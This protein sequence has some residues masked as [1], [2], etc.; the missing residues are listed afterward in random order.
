MTPSGIRIFS[1]RLL[2]IS[3]ATVA[4]ALIV[5]KLFVA[6]GADG[7]VISSINLNTSPWSAALDE[8]T[9]RLY[10]VNRSFGVLGGSILVQPSGSAGSYGYYASAPLNSA[11]SG[12]VQ[13]QN[14][15]SVVNARGSYVE[16]TVPVGDDPRDAAIDPAHGKVYVTSDD[17]ASVSV[18]D[19]RH[20][21]QSRTV[22]V[23]LR[24]HAV[25]VSGSTG[26]AF[27]V[28]T[29]D[30]TV[31][32]LDV[33]GSRVVRVVHVP[34][35]V[36][37]AGAAVDEATARVFVAGGGSV[38]LLDA[39]SGTMLKTVYLQSP[40][41]QQRY[42]QAGGGF[43]ETMT[44]VVVD[45]K[46]GR[47][48]ILNPGLLSVVDAGSGRLL[49]NIPVSA[50]ATALALDPRNGHLLMARAGDAG[51]SNALPGSG[52]LD[53]LDPA[54]GSTLQTFAVGVAPTAIVVDQR[55]GRVYVV[56]RGGEQQ[57]ANPL[58]WLPDGLRR[59]LPFASSDQPTTRLVPGGIFVLSLDNL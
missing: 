4:V 35:A 16:R 3:I 15:V 25:V 52:S 2:P 50:D 7:P 10:V 42:Y 40:D 30:G 6:R 46:A 48:Y 58:G 47:V 14:T 32:V 45:Q 37:S 22:H 51:G 54:S 31:S 28:N 1:R 23:G 59:H 53:V 18:L 43:N 38:S 13:F 12:S 9:G 24:P 34:S 19:E 36:D 55:A 17:E 44:Q 56:D 27:V 26:R 49:R 39:R 57:R 8:R 5:T 33:A 11:P 41:K 29:S 20:A 21:A